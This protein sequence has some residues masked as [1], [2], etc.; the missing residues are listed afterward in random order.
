MKIE[1]LFNELLK[2]YRTAGRT[3]IWERSIDIE[4]DFKKLDEEID[5][6]RKKFQE[7]LTE[8]R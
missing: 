2:K 3:A 5:E 4:Q 7:A 1:E 6:Y 8:L